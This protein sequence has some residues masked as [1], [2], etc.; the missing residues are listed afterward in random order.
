MRA[1]ATRFAGAAMLAAISACSAAD[2]LTD[3]E[4]LEEIDEIVQIEGE[5]ASR[6]V[7]YADAALL[8]RGFMRLPAVA[9]IRWPL[10][11]CFGRRAHS[12]LANASAHVR[13]LLQELPNETAGGWFRGPKL[14]TCAAACSR[15]A[16]LAELDSNAATRILCLDGLSRLSRQLELSP[17]AGDFA[18]AWLTADPATVDA[19]RTRV[20]AVCQGADGGVGD[21]DEDLAALTNKPLAGSEDRIVLVDQLQAWMMTA[22]GERSVKLAEGLR[23]SINHCVRGV[24]LRSVTGRSRALA[25]VRLCGMEQIRR[26]GGARAVPL[27]LAVMSASPAEM[28]NGVP[29]FDPDQLVRLRLIHYCGQLRADAALEV[30]RLPG[31]QDWE[32]A[33]AADFLART[34]LD[35]QDYYSQLRM[36]AII[37]LTWC[38]GRAEI[39]PDPSWVRDWLEERGT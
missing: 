30:V 18:D 20:A 35:E 28:A 16:W 33:S 4:L 32:S 15:F 25:E 27:L 19:A 8:S 11:W 14:Q 10:A 1:L 23:K 3:E 26:L 6:R 29:A 5:G 39:N 9:P 24:M 13:V 21:F 37:A 36:P 7:V 34:I 22:Q 2:V 12:E 17:F 38:L 31:R